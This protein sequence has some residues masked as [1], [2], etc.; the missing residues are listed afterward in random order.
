MPEYLTTTETAALLRV[1][2]LTLKRWRDRGEGPPFTRVGSRF[3]YPRAAL[4]AYLTP[5]R[6]ES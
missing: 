4:D 2:K 1:S 6:V 3:R 5:D